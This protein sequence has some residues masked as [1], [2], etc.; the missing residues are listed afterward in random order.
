MMLD[1]LKHTASRTNNPLKTSSRGQWMLFLQQNVGEATLQTR[2]YHY[3][4][5]QMVRNCRILSGI[6]HTDVVHMLPTTKARNTL[7]PKLQSH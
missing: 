7:K 5:I 3:Y 2:K 4:L 1:L 6:T